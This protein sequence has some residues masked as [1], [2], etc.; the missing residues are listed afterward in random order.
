M[1][2]LASLR[3]SESLRVGVHRLRHLR[4]IADDED[5]DWVL[6]DTSDEFDLENRQLINKCMEFEA[7]DDGVDIDVPLLGGFPQQ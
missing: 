5:E 4:H 3:M 7:E 1:T 6:Y 2:S